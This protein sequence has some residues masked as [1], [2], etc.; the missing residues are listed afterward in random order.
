MSPFGHFREDAVTPAWMA[1]FQ[2]AMAYSW[3]RFQTMVGEHYGIRWLPTYEESRNVSFAATA[4]CPVASWWPDLA[5]ASCQSS[6][7]CPLSLDRG[8]D[9]RPSRASTNSAVVACSAIPPLPRSSDPPSRSGRHPP[10]HER[11]FIRAC[12]F[13][14]RCSSARCHDKAEHCSL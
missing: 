13:F 5:V 7:R 1:Q 8:Q 10:V 14:A 9:C 4:P 11:R 12:Q 3:K 6:S 2:A